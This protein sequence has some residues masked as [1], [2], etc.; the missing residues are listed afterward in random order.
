MENR[1]S[2][3]GKKVHVVIDRPL[4]SAHPAF[5]NLVYP[6]NYG[7]VPGILAAD[8][9]EQDCYVLGVDHPIETF[10]GTIIGVIQRLDDVEDKWIVAKDGSH[11]SKEEILEQVHFQ[12]QFFKSEL[13]LL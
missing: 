13:I 8:G 11:F 7:Y 5:P 2:V 10:Q 9:E 6:L 12:E 4:G 3:L 1:I